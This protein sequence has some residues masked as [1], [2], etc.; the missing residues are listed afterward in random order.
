VPYNLF[1]YVTAAGKND[2]DKW[3]LGL[4][5]QQR[6][7][8]RAKLDMLA[9]QGDLAG[10]LIPAN[11]NIKKLRINGNVA[12]RPRVCA[13]PLHAN[14]YSLLLGVAKKDMTESP[15]NADGVAKMRRKEILDFGEIRRTPHVR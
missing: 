3:Q 6:G 14:E 15:A 13:G 9:L 5:P 8:L 10:V 12:V 2:F 4:Q 7:Q 1:D 11:G